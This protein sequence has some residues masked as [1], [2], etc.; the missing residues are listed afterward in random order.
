MKLKKFSAEIFAGIRD[1]EYEFKDG[2]NILLGDNEAGKSTVINAIFSALFTPAQIK[3]NRS[4][5]IEFKNQYLPYPDGD[6]AAA[7]LLFEVAEKEYKVYKKWSNSNYQ[8]FLELPG[9]ARI[10]A[11]AK[12]ADYKNELLNYGKS[13]Y[14]NIVFS[15]QKNIKSVLERISAE[16]NPELVDTINSFLRRAVMEL[17]GISIDQ[18]RNK[19]EAELEELTKKW[20]L[21]SMS[22]SN[23][24]RG[25]NNP[26]KVGTGKIY[27]SFIAKEKLKKEISGGKARE[28][29]F[30]KLNE[31]IN[32]LQKKEESLKN[33]INQLAEIEAEINQRAAL[34]IE[35]NNLTEKIEA[36]AKIKERWPQLQAELKELKLKKEKMETELNQLQQ[37]KV[38]AKKLKEKEALENTKKKIDK[39]ESAVKEIKEKISKNE[40]TAAAVNELENYK[41]DKEQAEA[42]LKAAKLKLKINFAAADKIK[43]KTGVG[44]EKEYQAG[45]VVEADGYLHLKTEDIDLEIESAEIDFSALKKSY[46][47]NKNN[48]QRLKNDLKV[49]NLKEAREKLNKLKELQ[50]ELRVKKE[51]LTELLA[52]NKQKEIERKLNDYQNLKSA[53]KLELIEAEIEAKTAAINK[54]KT[55]AAV[56]T[57]TIAEWEAEYQSL[58]EIKG[59]LKE[60]RKREEKIKAEL[61]ELASLPAEFDSAADFTKELKAKREKNELLN[62]NLREKLQQLKDLENKLP[63]ISAAEMEAQ[64]EKKEKRFKELVKKA[65]KLLKIKKV[66]QKNLKAVDQNSFSPLIESFNHNLKKLT[67]GK[68]QS[69]RINKDF[70]VAL[71]KEFNQIPANI[72]LLSYGTYDLVALALRFA[73]FENLFKGEEAFIVLD[74]CLVNLDPERKKRAVDLINS[75]QDKYQII[76]TSCNPEHIKDFEA[77]II[78]I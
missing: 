9:G 55:A 5:G 42:A 47:E 14:Q 72:K 4:Q 8:G 54:I 29:E 1:R 41:R 78:K 63:E 60:K 69:G 45:E 37:E 22:V 34:E 46:Q 39:L 57:N 12:I 74:D 7:E 6:Y 59:L 21:D 23:S 35:E 53:R 77:N 20:D 18:F 31:N 10:E 67:A 19:L 30:K 48:F 49:E 17:D 24:S 27:D 64:L 50:N 28:K 36:L 65:E 56:K 71:E 68:Y 76:Y 16:K 51:A 32:E 66:F 52:D 70:E 13:T 61:A 33:E 15:S 43:I 73:I 38:R 3:L 11:P 25:L 58:E 26:Y 44:E 40:I 62:Q 75:Y 2:L